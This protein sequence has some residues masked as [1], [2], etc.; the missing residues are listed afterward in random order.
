MPEII[1]LGW[2][3]TIMGIVALVSGAS[4]LFKYKEISHRTR[5]GQIYLL[6]TFI[7]PL[8]VIAGWNSIKARPAQYFAAFLVLEGLMVGPCDGSEDGVKL[9]SKEGV[10][11]GCVLGS[12]EGMPDGLLDNVGSSDIINV[13][14]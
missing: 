3:H 12:T 4:T 5:S 2:F 10:L 11:D 8:V 14:P 6:T 9:G 1:P 7:T 13:G